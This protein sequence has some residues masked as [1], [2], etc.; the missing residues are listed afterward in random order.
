[1]DRLRCSTVDEVFSW[2]AGFAF[3]AVRISRTSQDLNRFGLRVYS[4]VRL[5]SLQVVGTMGTVGAS[6]VHLSFCEVAR[7]RAVD[8]LGEVFHTRSMNGP[9][10]VTVGVSTKGRH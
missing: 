6:G 9:V 3:G 4:G 2:G 10:R 1:M 7:K 8:K 5:R